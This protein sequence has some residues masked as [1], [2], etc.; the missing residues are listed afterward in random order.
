MLIC[1][2]AVLYCSS[3]QYLKSKLNLDAHWETTKIHLDTYLLVIKLDNITFNTEKI[4]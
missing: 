4:L 3:T 1:Y 2:D